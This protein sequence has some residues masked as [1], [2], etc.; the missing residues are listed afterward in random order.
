[1]QSQGGNIIGNRVYSMS[2]QAK[3]LNLFLAILLIVVCSVIPLPLS[4]ID[5][6]SNLVSIGF[7]LLLLSLGLKLIL[8]IFIS[9]V[10]WNRDSICVKGVFGSNCVLRTE[11]K[12]WKSQ[13]TRRG[14][15]ILF[16]GENEN[17]A[18][19]T[20]PK[21][22]QFDGEWNVWFSS[23]KSIDKEIRDAF[24]LDTLPK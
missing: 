21:V 13:Y 1:M 20:M 8:N 23:L 3:I 9:K 12:A 15:F 22:F 24:N 11:I 16:Y 5:G 10:I 17:S 18:L 6:T 4:D 19:L 7:H 14:N 2:M